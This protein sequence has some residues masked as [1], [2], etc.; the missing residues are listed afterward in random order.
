MATLEGFPKGDTLFVGTWGPP[1]DPEELW[2]PAPNPEDFSFED[3]HDVIDT[4]KFYDEKHFAKFIDE[5]ESSFEELDKKIVEARNYNPDDF[6]EPTQVI[7]LPLLPSLAGDWPNPFAYPTIIELMIHE[8][9]FMENQEVEDLEITE[10][11]FKKHWWDIDVI[12]DEL[13]ATPAEKVERFL[14]NQI[15]IK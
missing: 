4:V 12:R 2:G 9:V 13:N 15:S 7:P 1:I 14:K 3:V 11:K 8:A 6:K 10:P 5:Y